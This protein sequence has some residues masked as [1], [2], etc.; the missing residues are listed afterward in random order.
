MLDSG[1]RHIIKCISLACEYYFHS[2]VLP[3]WLKDRCLKVEANHVAYRLLIA[4]AT[5]QYVC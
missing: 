2:V 3:D 4:D 5:V 1:G